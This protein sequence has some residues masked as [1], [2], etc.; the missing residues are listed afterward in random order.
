M[1][2]HLLQSEGIRT[3]PQLESSIQKTEDEIRELERQRSKADNKRR[4]AKTPEE[5]QEAKKERV[6]LTKHITP[7]RKKLKEEKRICE[8]IPQL[9]QLLQTEYTMEHNREEKSRIRTRDARSR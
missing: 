8:N 6:A 5:K 3:L 4:R 9:Y 7:L 2:Y 1:R